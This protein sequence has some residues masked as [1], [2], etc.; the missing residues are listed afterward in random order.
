ML[1]AMKGRN[2]GT[3]GQSLSRRGKWTLGLIGAFLLVAIA[4]VGVWSAVGPGSY[5][6]SGHGCI[7]LT[8]VSSTGG[9]VI[10]DCGAKA[11]AVCQN[12]SGRTGKLAR[13]TRQQ[14]K[15]AGLS[16]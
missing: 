8:V 2:P 5:A 15:L 10:H 11:R 14:C 9:G 12:A 4:G 6:R 7:N 16:P 13:L 3:F 1:G